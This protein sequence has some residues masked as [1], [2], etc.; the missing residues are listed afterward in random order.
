MV[1][2]E[3]DVTEITRKYR[4]VAVVE[5]LPLFLLSFIFT[6]RKIIVRKN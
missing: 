5:M 3:H 2:T 1:W 6:K 4:V